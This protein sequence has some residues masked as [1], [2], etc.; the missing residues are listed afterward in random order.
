MIDEVAAFALSNDEPDF[1]N[2]TL[3]DQGDQMSFALKKS[4]KI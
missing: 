4:S 2:S 3:W 1:F